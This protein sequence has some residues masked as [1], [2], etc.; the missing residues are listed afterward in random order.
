MLDIAPEKRSLRA[1][2]SCWQQMLCVPSV[3]RC[4]GKVQG[5]CTQARFEVQSP[6]LLSEEGVRGG[7]GRC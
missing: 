5:V 1:A 2:C 4:R 7:A 6:L 3:T